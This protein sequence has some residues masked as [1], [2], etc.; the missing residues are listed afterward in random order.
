MKLEHKAI[1]WPEL[2]DC[3]QENASHWNF[4]L[5]AVGNHCDQRPCAK[6]LAEEASSGG[7]GMEQ[8]IIWLVHDAHATFSS[9]DQL[10]TN[11]LLPLWATG[12]NSSQRPWQSRATLQAIDVSCPLPLHAKCIPEALNSACDLDFQC[13][14][15]QSSARLVDTCLTCCSILQASF[16]V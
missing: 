2:P 11:S 13:V 12:S 9:I 6:H 5:S 8:A 1:P 14:A 7:F 16:E 4:E 10:H 3:A 15:L